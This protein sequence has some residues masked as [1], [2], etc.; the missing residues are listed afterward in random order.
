MGLSFDKKGLRGAAAV[1]AVTALALGLPTLA[2]AQETLT[3][4]SAISLTGK[5]SS[6]GVDAQNGYD[7]AVKNRRQDLQP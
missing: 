7:L 1:A 4:G 2:A 3:L 5:Y 6:N